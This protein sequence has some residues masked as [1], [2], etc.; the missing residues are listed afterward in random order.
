MSNLAAVEPSGIT[1]E[2]VGE[3]SGRPDVVIIRAGVAVLRPTVAEAVAEGATR[4]AAVRDA[5]AAAGIAPEAVSTVQYSV[6]PRHAERRIEGYE[7][8][9]ILAVRSP[10]ISGA[11]D[12]I[13]AV[14][15][16]AGDA[17]RLHGISL[18]IEDPTELQR[19]A[20]G[21]AWEDAHA[22]ARQ[23]AD[24]AGLGLGAATT[25]VEGVPSQGVPRAMM[26]RSAEMAPQIEGGSQVVTVSL[27]VTFD[28]A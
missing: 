21:R 7:V 6:Q 10:D 27:R 15:T 19:V 28:I 12:L 5:V 25:I 2:G 9:D 3:A 22:K 1:V 17:A 24:L 16:A 11:G 14:T 18:D 4:A 13:A 23:L 20:R 26:A 8:T